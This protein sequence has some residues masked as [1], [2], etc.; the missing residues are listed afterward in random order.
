MFRLTAPILMSRIFELFFILDDHGLVQVQTGSKRNPKSDGRSK[1]L[2]FIYVKNYF[3]SKYCK[4]LLL[5]F[6]DIVYKI[7][8]NTLML[9]IHVTE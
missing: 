6:S 8:L 5:H 7:R 9:D 2:L 3:Q 4:C 1:H